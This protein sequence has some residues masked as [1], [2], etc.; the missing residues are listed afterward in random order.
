[1]SQSSFRV[2]ELAA[3]K[4]RAPDEETPPL[5]QQK[6][7]KTK[8]PRWTE[9]TLSYALQGLVDLVRA[10]KQTDNNGFKSP[11]LQQVCEKLQ[12]EHRVLYTHENL[13]AKWAEMKKMWKLWTQ[14]LG[15]VSGWGRNEND[16]PVNEKGVEDEYF[17]AHQDCR[18]FRGKGPPCRDLMEQLL[19]GQAA[20]GEFAGSLDEILAQGENEEEEV[21]VGPSDHGFGEVEM[22]GSLGMQGEEELDDGLDDGASDTSIETVGVIE[23]PSNTGRGRPNAATT[24]TTTTTASASAT[25]AP[26]RVS[27]PKPSASRS[28]RKED[29]S[30]ASL[31]RHMRNSTQAIMELAKAHERPPPAAESALTRA[32]ALVSALEPVA[33]MPFARRFAL[34]RALGLD[35][36]AETILGLVEH[37]VQPYVDMMLAD[38]DAARLQEFGGPNFDPNLLYR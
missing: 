29:A 34:L 6:K 15:R 1:M 11:D 8:P 37:D 12:R 36:H 27:T 22:S 13:K 3:R 26:R 7:Q 31:E 18:R 35:R 30:T 16:V 23:T 14:H 4:R 2:P 5:Q 10:G 32:T 17:K 33:T 21:V 28:H 38:I 20:T 9:E 25:P 19:G 24:T